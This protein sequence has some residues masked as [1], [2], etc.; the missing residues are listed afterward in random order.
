MCRA[1]Y[2]LMAF[3]N[4]L[5]QLCHCCILALSHCQIFWALLLYSHL[6][7]QSSKLERTFIWVCEVCVLNPPE[8]QRVRDAGQVLILSLLQNSWLVPPSPSPQQSSFQGVKTFQS[9]L[10]KLEKKILKTFL[11]FSLLWCN[12]QEQQQQASHAGLP[13]GL[14]S[15]MKAAAKVQSELSWRRRGRR[16]S[17]QGWKRFSFMAC[18]LISIVARSRKKKD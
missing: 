13:F 8:E 17:Q 14:C 15:R 2:V 10:F 9:L 5:L 6:K 7:L 4:L 16:P 1:A 11:P 18:Q 12:V 3:P